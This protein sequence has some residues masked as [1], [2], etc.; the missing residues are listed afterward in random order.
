MRAQ[1]VLSD[2][3]F[4]GINKPTGSLRLVARDPVRGRNY[5]LGG[6]TTHINGVQVGAF[7]RVSDFGQLDLAWTGELAAPFLRSTL[8]LGNGELMFRDGLLSNAAWQ[9]LRQRANG[10]YV[11]EP[12]RWTNEPLL[13]DNTF[14]TASD[15]QG[16]TYAVFNR[17]STAGASLATLRR[18]NADGVPDAAWRADIEAVPNSIAQLAISADGSVFYVATRTEGT[19]TTNTLG[20]TSAS[21][22]LRWSTPFG[23]TFAGLAT[24][25]VGRAYVFG[26]KVALQGSVGTLLRVGRT[27]NIDAGWMP[28]ADGAA[29][30]SA[31]SLR[32]LDDR[33]V[34]VTASGTEPPLIRL[35]SLADGRALASRSAPAGTTF[36]LIDAAGTVVLYVDAKLVL[37]SPTATDFAVRDVAVKAGSAPYVAAIQRWSAGYVVGGQFE[38]AFGGV[39]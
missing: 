27:G 33:A 20:R 30:I 34:V 18:V 8:L 31:A 7:S 19:T 11:V 22:T 9:R 32:V 1:S 23:G 25:A 13:Q 5:V 16:N 21:D 26:E 28:L 39:R 15:S 10:G 3:D 37:W 2:P 35:I 12:F 14:A 17:L 24:D 29:T 38:Y 6:S 4:S 36:A